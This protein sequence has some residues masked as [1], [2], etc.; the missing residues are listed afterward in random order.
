M[1]HALINDVIMNLKMENI[2]IMKQAL[3]EC[4]I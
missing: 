1:E 4:I 2:C 3:R